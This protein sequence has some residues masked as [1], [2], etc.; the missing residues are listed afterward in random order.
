MALATEA[1]S[2]HEIA[3]ALLESARLC[4]QQGRQENAVDLA[5][6]AAE[7]FAQ[8]GARLDLEEALMIADVEGGPR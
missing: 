3:R 1:Q 8:L 5:Q 4:R 6:Q 2:R 7:M